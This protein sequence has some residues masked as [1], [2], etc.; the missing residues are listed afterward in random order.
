MSAEPA[1]TVSR[2][3]K[4]CEMPPISWPRLSSRRRWSSWRLSPRASMWSVVSVTMQTTPAYWPC[5]SIS[6]IML[7]RTLRCEPSAR[8]SRVAPT[9]ERPAW[10][11]A[12]R[13]VSSFWPWSSRKPRSETPTSCCAG[14]P[15]DDA[16]RLV[17][18]RGHALRV[19]LQHALRD[20]LQDPAVAS[21]RW[22]AAAPGPGP[23]TAPGHSSPAMS[24]ASST[25]AV[26]VE[27]AGPRPGQDQIAGVGVVDDHRAQHGGV[28]RWCPSRRCQRLDRPSRGQHD[29]AGGWRP[30][31]WRSRRPGSSP[32]PVQ[33]PAERRRA[34]RRR[35]GGR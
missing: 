23:R 17:R 9:V 33:Q 15:E 7:I 21:P 5:S 35:G 34:A 18:V 28:D 12:S 22:P 30:A 2:L 13:R 11:S 26:G 27:G 32:G 8:I 29:R 6:G 1:T 31:R 24:R 3:L 14:Q 10:H 16:D 25:S 4:S 20:G 19:E